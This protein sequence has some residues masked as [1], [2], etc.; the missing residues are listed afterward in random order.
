MSDPQAAARN[1]FFQELKPHCIAINNLSV[2]ASDKK[3]IAKDL[4]HEVEDLFV[5]LDRPSPPGVAS[6]DHKLADY[7]FFPLSN[8]LRSQDQF[9][10]RLIELT[11]K[12][13]T[14]LIDAGWKSH[15]PVDLGQQLLILLAFIIGG[16]PGQTIKR[17]LPEETELEAFRALN[18]LVRAAGS[19]AAGAAALVDARAIPTLGHAVSVVLEGITDGR[20]S[21]I[22]MEALQTVAALHASIK[23]KTALA[24]FLPGIISALSKLLSPPI[25]PKA[26]RK[27]LI[28][29]L[30][31]TTS[32]LCGV[33]GDLHVRSILPRAGKSDSD[34]QQNDDNTKVLTVPWLRATSAKV[35]VALAHVLKLR[36]HTEEDVRSEVAKMCLSL[37]DECHQS[38]SNCASILVETALI[39]SQPG[40]TNKARETS[41]EDLA[42]IYPELCDTIKMVVYNWEG[43]LSRQMQASNEKLK[44]QAVSNLSKGHRIISNLQ[45]NSSMLD[46]A[47]V[48]SLRD[49]AA[50]ALISTGL[51]GESNG[52]NLVMIKDSSFEDQSFPPVIF[53]K[54]Q[55]LPTRT[56][57]VAFLDELGHSPQ[58]AWLPETMLTHCREASGEQQVAAFWLS[59]ELLKSQLKHESDIDNFLDLTGA[60]D[61]DDG[62][63]LVFDELY[64][65]SVSILDTSEDEGNMD[66][67][68]Q[69]LAMEVTT[70]AAS[71]L[72]QKF[73]PELIDSLYPITTFLGATTPTIRDHAMIA[74]NNIASSCGYP[75]VTDLV[76][77]NVDYMVNSYSL[78]LNT[79]DITPAS[80]QVLRMMVQL[81]GPRLVPY[82]DD[83][84]ASIFGALDNYH[85]YPNLVEGLFSVLGEIA[86]Q[87]AAS[88]KLSLT[89]HSFKS[90]RKFATRQ[91]GLHDVQGSLVAILDRQDHNR[92]TNWDDDSDLSHPKRPWRDTV[93]KTAKELLDEHGEDENNDADEE[94]Q[95]N[96]GEKPPVP[97]T[98]TFKI[99]ARIT[100]FT[101]H[102]MTSPSASLRRSLLELLCTVCP[103]IAADEEAFLPLVNAIWPVTVE[104][105]YDSET[106]VVISACKALAAL[107][108][109]S[110]D[111][112]SSRVKTEWWDQLGQWFSSKKTAAKQKRVTSGSTDSKT[113]PR[114][115][116]VL[117]VRPSNGRF[118]GADEAAPPI[119][120]DSFSHASQVWQAAR[121]LLTALVS[122]VQIDDQI[123]DSIL[124]LVAEDLASDIGLRAALS[125]VDS[126]SVWLQ[127]YE[128]GMVRPGQQPRMV[129]A[130]FATI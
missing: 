85:G 72:G 76:V 19:S 88:S 68:L 57:L 37:L 97:Q 81:T 33:L 51:L 62:A 1:A 69:A 105:L 16:N 82:L 30:M 63:E 108:E 61:C 26:Q 107:F 44:L 119:R 60:S 54:P 130:G 50:T 59:F 79:F 128:H 2:R 8:I 74:L 117:T 45:I 95:A 48:A 14:I 124:R 52:P 21:D 28:Q 42:R 127:M 99:L 66:W 36:N 18:A 77:D 80:T 3:A 6:L 126:D 115:S 46:S 35:Q 125:A 70:F 90:H 38:L 102:Y 23:D 73:R 78:R 34:D 91:I 100:T 11:L 110:G 120:F 104:R 94:E 12:C 101:Q 10:V 4:I 111:F 58:Y 55:E 65:L 13:L 24:T 43:S 64:A 5:L 83:V 29:G 113:G 92:K 56:A 93:T 86:Y 39:L 75:S 17:P 71:R 118:S 47:L 98:P 89:E 31:V 22:Q 49:T 121:Q 15:L 122:F 87:G 20:T 40:D 32:I 9:P 116:L 7:V 25:S 103:A 106:F 41:L 67:R 96:E 27:V 123:F 112:L 84:V 114:G 53:T 129:P 109:C